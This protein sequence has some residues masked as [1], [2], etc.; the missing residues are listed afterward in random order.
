MHPRM[1]HSHR[2]MRWWL[3]QCTKSEKAD[4]ESSRTKIVAE[5]LI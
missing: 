3:D 2:L 5:G 1:S 4:L